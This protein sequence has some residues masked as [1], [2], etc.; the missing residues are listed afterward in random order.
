[1]FFCFSLDYVVLTLFAFI[2]L[3]L[4]SSVLRQL[5]WLGK[6]SPKWPILCRVGRKP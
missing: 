2:V 6:T 3:D 1:V 5:Y 4:V